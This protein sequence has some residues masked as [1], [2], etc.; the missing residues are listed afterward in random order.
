VKG[1]ILTRQWRDTP[2]GIQLELWL[3]TDQQPVQLL[4]PQ[5]YAV[6][7][8]CESQTQQVKSLLGSSATFKTVNLKNYHGQK[9]SA[10]YCRQRSQIKD[11]ASLLRSK[12]V[13]VWED[14]IKPVD[15]FLMERFIT[16]GVELKNQ[17]AHKQTKNYI[18]VIDHQL[19]ACTYKPKLKLV[20]LDIETSFDTQELYS[21]GVFNQDHA[22][23]FMVGDHSLDNKHQDAEFELIWCASAKDCLQQFIQWLHI[24]DPDVIIGWHVVQF[25]LWVLQQLCDRWQVKFAIGRGNQSLHWRDDSRN[26]NR[27]YVQVPGRIILDGIELLRTAFYHFESYTLQH[28]AHELLGDSKLLS[29]DDRADAIENLFK[30]DKAALARYNLKDCQLVWEIFKNTALL[31]F[32]IERSAL[33]GLAMDRMGGSVASFEN[34]Y[35]PKLHRAGYVAPNLG[36]LQSDVVSPGGYVMHSRPGL[37]RN[38]LVLDFKSLYPSIIR[39]F[40]I[41]PYGF[42]VATHENLTK[43]NTIEGFNGARFSRQQNIL[44]NII[45]NLWQARDAAKAENN[46]ALSQAIKIIMNSFYGVLGSQGCRFFDPRVCSSITLRGHEIIQRSRDWISDQGYEVIYGDT[47]SLFVWLGDKQTDSGAKRKGRE[48][49]EGL[50]DWWQKSLKDEMNIESALEIE[51]ETHYQHFLMPTIRGSTKG[52]K[53]RYAGIVSDF[54]NEVTNEKLVFKGLETVRS[55]WTQ[56]A[57]EFQQTLYL[58]IFKRQPYQKYISALLTQLLAGQLDYQLVYKKRLRRALDAYEKT[59]PP[60]VKAARRLQEM[61]GKLLGRGDS[62]HYVLT[63]NGPEPIETQQSLIDYQHYI[64][65]QLKPIA[66]SILVF[67]DDEFDRIANQQMALI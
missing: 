57:K 50:N 66:D 53:K 59:S 27:H 1:F 56:L 41:D 6:C 25:D 28:V 61:T 12:A 43:D 36:E 62:I 21:I 34:A 13:E 29:H 64:D 32:A 26:E 46:A 23:V 2:Q 7:F 10:L 49:A 67:V 52:S 3:A 15:R 58:K 51:F 35:L 31:E 40:A 44:P 18:R 39:T 60:H 9:V 37:Y 22:T 17:K 45:A 4:I 5:Q 33:T 24:V 55:D 42:W 47:D 8:F 65:K 38:I 20:S 54:E 11:I 63:V 14:D 19:R 30:T 48:L 16:A